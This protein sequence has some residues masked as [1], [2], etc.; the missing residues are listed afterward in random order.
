MTL[1]EPY[2]EDTV[3]RTVRGPKMLL[4]RAFFAQ[5]SVLKVLL[6]DRNEC[7]FH[8]G[9]KTPAGWEWKKAKFNDMELGEILL[10]LQGR[11][12]KTAFYHSFDG[13]GGK[14]TT[15]IWVNRGGGHCT[16]K[17]KEASKSLTEAEQKVL[18]TLLQHAIVLMNLTL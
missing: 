14:V 1:A 17:V 12:E 13:Q 15:Q 3:V 18:E 11:K 2:P 4:Q 5:E 9:W 6:N 16:F 10:V 7:Y 8:W